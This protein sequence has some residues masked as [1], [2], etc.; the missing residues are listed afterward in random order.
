MR[1]C[2]QGDVIVGS[3][4]GIVGSSGA[5]KEGY[6]RCWW[7]GR[8]CDAGLCPHYQTSLPMNGLWRRSATRQKK[9]N[10]PSLTELNWVW[11]SHMCSKSFFYLPLLLGWPVSKCQ[12]LDFLKEKYVC[13]SDLGCPDIC[14]MS[15]HTPTLD[16]L[17]DSC[18]CLKLQGS[19][20]KDLPEGLFTELASTAVNR[21]AWYQS[22]F[23]MRACCSPSWLVVVVKRPNLTNPR[24]SLF[25]N[26]SWTNAV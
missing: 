5:G 15:V 7:N 8:Y 18:Y 16:C 3:S 24:C 25:S 17:S 26:I 4:G 20:R 21:T 6:G 2:P 19:Q 11:Y 14:P 23:T 10:H 12:D 13:G 1:Y 9:L 22:C